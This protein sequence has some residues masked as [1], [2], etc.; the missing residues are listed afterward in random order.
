MAVRV[1]VVRGLC[2]KPEAHQRD[3]AGR[4]VGKV[5]H[6]VGRNGDAAE[7]RAHRQLGRTQQ[8]VA[9]NAHRARQIAVSG[10]HGRVVHVRAVFDKAFY[11]KVRQSRR[12]FSR[13]IQIS[14]SF[15]YTAKEA[16]VQPGGRRFAQ[17][18]PAFLRQGDGFPAACCASPLLFGMIQLRSSFTAVHIYIRRCSG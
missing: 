4:G 8:H 3:D 12:L 18:A 11:Q 15:Y 10:A 1:F 9:E 14:D 5:V 2:R 7:Q 13:I 16:K 17:A 6:R